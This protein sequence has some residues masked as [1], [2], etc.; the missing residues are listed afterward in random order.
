V[1]SSLKTCRGRKVCQGKDLANTG[2]YSLVLSSIIKSFVQCFR[3]LSS[4]SKK[5]SSDSQELSWVS[6]HCHACLQKLQ[7]FHRTPLYTLWQSNMAMGNPPNIDGFSYLNAHWTL[8]FRGISH[9]H[10]KLRKPEGDVRILLLWNGSKLGNGSE[11]ARIRHLN[12][13]RMGQGT[14]T[15]LEVWKNYWEIP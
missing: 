5:L 15:P 4:I 6:R 12:K 7:W 3:T 13:L 14:K 11:A 1:K 9:C 8:H 10:V 2:G